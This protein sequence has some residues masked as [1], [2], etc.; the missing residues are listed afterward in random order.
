MVATGPHNQSES[1]CLYGSLCISKVLISVVLTAEN[2]PIGVDRTSYTF[3]HNL[4]FRHL[5]NLKHRKRRV[6]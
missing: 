6:I 5:M 1:C 2:V 4:I 3:S